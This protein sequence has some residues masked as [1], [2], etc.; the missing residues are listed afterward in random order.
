[1]PNLFFA[2]QELENSKRAFHQFKQMKVFEPLNKDFQGFIMHLDLVFIK[3]ERGCQDIKS[4]FQP[5]QGKYKKLR[6]EDPL[7]SYLKNAR[8]AINH[9]NA[10][11]YDFEDTNILADIVKMTHKD[12]HGNEIIE[13]IPVF[14][15]VI[16][17]KKFKINNQEWL[18]PTMHLGQ[19]LFCRADPTEVATLA[20]KFYEDFLKERDCPTK[21]V[22]K[23]YG[24]QLCSL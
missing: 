15:S 9:D 23:K 8:D 24:V 10:T 2:E 17:L 20:F 1:M 19:P 5:F 3:A 11:I 21:C 14:E 4:K 12:G 16:K 18:P 13:E 7:L 22:N 6:R